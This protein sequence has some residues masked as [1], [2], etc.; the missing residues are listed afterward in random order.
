MSGTVSEH[1]K[2]VHPNIKSIWLKMSKILSSVLLVTVLHVSCRN[3]R[4]GHWPGHRGSVSKELTV[5]VDLASG[6]EE[7]PAAG[8]R[9]PQHRGAT[10]AVIH[11][12]Y[13]VVTVILHAAAPVNIT[14]HCDCIAG[15]RRAD[16]FTG[17]I[18]VDWTQQLGL[19]QW[20]AMEQR[21]PLQI[22][23][24]GPRLVKPC[25]VLWQE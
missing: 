10:R 11:L 15:R 20:M 23:K 6:Q 19:W 2:L 9:P 13:K 7:L 16:K 17:I 5:S 25:N 18:P 21:K 3:V 14:E 8:S 1:Y 12:R 22:F 24:L 4:L